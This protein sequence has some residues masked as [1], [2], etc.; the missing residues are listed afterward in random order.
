VKIKFILTLKKS[1]Q[2]INP[3]FLV[4]FFSQH[5]F[6]LTQ[7]HFHP[8]LSIMLILHI[9]YF[10]F[11]DF[12]KVTI[13]IAELSFTIAFVFTIVAI[14]IVTIDFIWVKKD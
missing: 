6:L 11:Y 4:K 13:V 12:T 5:L 2:I 7:D 3:T 10:H 9:I 1:N 8:T 14:T